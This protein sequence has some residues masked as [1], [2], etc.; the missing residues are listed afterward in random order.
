MKMP[1][2]FKL[3]TL[4][5]S[6][7]F[8]SCTKHKEKFE[9]PE[10]LNKSEA[11]SVA[12]GSKL[13]S[14]YVGTI[15]FID[16]I[17]ITEGFFSDYPTIIDNNKEEKE[18][19][20]LF[21]I[22]IDARSPVRYSCSKCPLFK[23]SFF[24]IYYVNNSSDTLQLTNFEDGFPAYLEYQGDSQE[25]WIRLQDTLSTEKNRLIIL[26]PAKHAAVVLVPYYRTHQSILRI[27]TKNNNQYIPSPLFSLSI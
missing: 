9:L 12:S 24:P 5:F 7:L 15:P 13:I 2:Y 22:H 11:V 8:S 1:S 3:I 18:N 10:V 26:V 4:L 20:H 16:E 19:V 14:W 23:H 21:D 27:I 6:L 17:E 25:E